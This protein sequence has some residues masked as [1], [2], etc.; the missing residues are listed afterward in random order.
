M[1][2]GSPGPLEE[3]MP[4]RRSKRKSVQAA[5]AGTPAVQA[6]AASSMRKTRSEAA[7]DNTYRIVILNNTSFVDLPPTFCVSRVL[8]CY[9]SVWGPEYL[10]TIA[11]YWGYKIRN[12][13]EKLENL[14]L[15][16]LVTILWSLLALF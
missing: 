15:L 11:L 5:I 14:A 7:E 8:A 16:A 12:L 9:A 3:V 10:W 1:D 6:R 13:L 2:G 4:E